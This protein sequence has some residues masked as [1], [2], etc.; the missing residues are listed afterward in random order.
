MSNTIAIETLQQKRQ[1]LLLEKESFLDRINGEISSIEAVIE[2]LSGKKVW[3]IEKEF[4]YD[5]ENPN[6]IRASIEEI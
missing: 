2:T 6:Y 3:E 1:Q 5:D 4:V